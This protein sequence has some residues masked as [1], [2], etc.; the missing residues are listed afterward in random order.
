MGD[1]DTTA[2]FIQALQ[3]GSLADLTTIPKSDIH[4]HASRGGNIKYFSEWAKANINPPD[5]PFADISEMQHWFNVNI[6][7][8]YHGITG[9][10]KCLELAF[11]QARE[12]NLKVLAMSFGIPG[13]DSLGG[14]D[15]FSG[16][17]D[18]YHRLHAPG[19]AIYP[20]L[21][22]RREANTDHISNRLDE[23]LSKNWFRSIDNCG[24]EQ[25]QRISKFKQ[26]YQKASQY[27]LRL[28]AHIG[29]YGNA[30][31]V[32]EAVEQLELSEVHH[33]IAAAQSEAVMNWLANHNIQQ[34]GLRRIPG[35]ISKQRSF[36]GRTRSY[37]AEWADGS[38]MTV[39]LHYSERKHLP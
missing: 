34:V 3:S 32:R 1:K 21:A 12:D 24:Y 9:Y 6:K 28:K 26:I 8:N 16:M 23:L 39:P 36:T 14:I 18:I 10:L 27:G 37:Q 19:T 35:F 29:E 7:S 33:G 4:N 38:N 13:I 31:D 30:D 25:A 22:L 20:E 2:S 15:N 5:Q 11:I 17:V